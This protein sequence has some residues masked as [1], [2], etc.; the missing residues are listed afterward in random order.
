MPK[1]EQLQY[2]AYSY[3]SQAV[4]IRLKKIP[5]G[6]SECTIRLWKG[7]PACPVHLC[8]CVLFKVVPGVKVYR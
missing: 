3:L 2:H 6:V 4:F 8:T 1:E 7:L 5:E